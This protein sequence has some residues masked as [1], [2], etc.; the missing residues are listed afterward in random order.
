MVHRR[1]DSNPRGH[2][3]VEHPTDAMLH[4]LGH[5]GINPIVSTLGVAVNRTRQ[6]PF[7][8]IDQLHD[9]IDRFAHGYE[10]CISKGLGL[11]H[12][13]ILKELLACDP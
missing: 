3:V 5:R 13:R 6:V 12:M 10:H 2:L 7:E 11:E 9:L 1:T 8:R 4:R